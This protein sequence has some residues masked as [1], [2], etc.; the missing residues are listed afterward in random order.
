MKEHNSTPVVSDYRRRVIKASLAAAPMILTLGPGSATARSSFEDKCDEI[1]PVE[2][3]PDGTI[4]E[5]EYSLNGRAITSSCWHSV[6]PNGDERHID[7]F[8]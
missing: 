8:W 7:G 4:K 5:P 3:N 2:Y 1:P 6:S